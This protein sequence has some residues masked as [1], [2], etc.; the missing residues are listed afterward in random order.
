MQDE[1][2]SGTESMQIIQNMINKAKNQFNENGF[3]YLLW[4]WA[5]LV[6]SVA[7][8]ILL[9][10]LQFPQHYMVWMLTWLVF[11]VQVLYLRRQQRSRRV[12][13]YTEDI[14]KYVWITF[15]FV[16]FL[17]SF[18]L[19]RLM[20]DE[21]YRFLN[22][23]ILIVYG[24]PTFLSGIILRFRPLKIGG[25]SCWGL[26]VIATF[27]AYDYQLLLLSAAVTVAWIVPGYMLRAR[28]KKVNS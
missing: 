19:G 17:M 4:G 6:C 12:E 28:F 2:I 5:I 23:V 8:F 25:L 20:G 11:I 15:V 3:L 16:M 24:I 22:P 13:T 21:Y 26:S 10:L 27:I 18:V 9:H 7:Q 1:Q 14:L